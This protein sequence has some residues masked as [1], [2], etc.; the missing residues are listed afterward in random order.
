MWYPAPT[1]WRRTVRHVLKGSGIFMSTG[2]LA[3]TR[4]IAAIT[5]LLGLFVLIVGGFL[6]LKGDYIVSGVGALISL[7]SWLAA[8]YI[9]FRAS[10]LGWLIF[11]A[12]IA[13]FGVILAII[14]LVLLSVSDQRFGAIF[15]LTFGLLATG[16][17][18]AGAVNSEDVV[19]RPVAA[20]LGATGFVLMIIGGTIIGNSVGAPAIIGGLENEIGDHL[21]LV[22]GV[23][24]LAAWV[25]GMVTA[26]R[27]KAWGWFVFA[28]LLPGI[29]AFMFGLF[30]PSA[31]DV[32][33]ARENAEARRAAG[34]RV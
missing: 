13:V 30:G 16:G 25:I 17:F 6:I 5:G 23:L 31:Q 21:Y 29:G 27:I 3:L 2:A 24:G 19:A 33:Q 18:V 4:R 20:T 15:V 1:R 22:S 12:Y 10:R 9:G 26:F 11:E 34:V 8:V 14:S 28:V 32:K 7:V